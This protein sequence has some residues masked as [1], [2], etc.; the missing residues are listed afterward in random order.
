MEQT[1]TPTGGTVAG[2]VTE[3]V[4]SAEPT[5]DNPTAPVAGTEADTEAA[6]VGLTQEQ[7]DQVVKDRVKREK[8]KATEAMGAL[9]AELAEYRS[10][11]KATEDAA[12]SELQL[13]LEAKQAAEAAMAE[14]QAAQA[15]AERKALVAGIVAA[16]A[17]GLPPPFLALISGDDTESI[18]DSIAEL[19]ALGTAQWGG[20][21]VA[22]PV[23]APQKTDIG[24]AGA[25]PVNAV[26]QPLS[27]EDRKAAEM[28]QTVVDNAILSNPA[29]H[30][31]TEFSEAS[32]RMVER[33]TRRVVVG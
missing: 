12:K 30:T 6:P 31:A 7:V 5:V 13:A 3:P 8:A 32:R 11:R 18:T 17:P 1:T 9:E 14:A 20:N 24:S 29:S 27:T 22:A 25:P 19:T 2:T 15:T 26:M 21:G 23:T 4:V 28:A 33:S 16:Q 10:Q